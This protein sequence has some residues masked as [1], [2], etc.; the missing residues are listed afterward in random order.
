MVLCVETD[1]RGTHLRM[2]K[3]STVARIAARAGH[4]QVSS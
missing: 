1:K 4:A 3:A 2:R